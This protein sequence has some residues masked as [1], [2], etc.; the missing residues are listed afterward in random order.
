MRIVLVRYPALGLFLNGPPAVKFHSGRSN[1]VINGKNVMIMNFKDYNA[2]RPNETAVHSEMC[3]G[4]V[5]RTAV[6]VLFVEGMD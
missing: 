6:I 4:P 2:G 5:T 1:N 3:S